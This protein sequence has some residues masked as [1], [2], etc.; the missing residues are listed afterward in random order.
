MYVGGICLGSCLEMVFPKK[1]IRSV[2]VLLRNFPFLV[3]LHKGRE[4]IQKKFSGYYAYS[5]S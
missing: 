5:D 2:W 3:G 1:S 4:L